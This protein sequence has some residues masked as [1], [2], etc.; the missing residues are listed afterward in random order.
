MKQRSKRVQSC[1]EMSQR[2]AIV[3]CVGVNSQSRNHP[4][5]P[6]SSFLFF[7]VSFF[8]IRIRTRIHSH[9]V[10]YLFIRSLSLRSIF[11][12]QSPKSKHPHKGSISF[13]FISFFHIYFRSHSVQYFFHNGAYS[14]CREIKTSALGNSFF[15]LHF[16]LSHSHSL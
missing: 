3:R 10:R 6:P 8:H 7:G 1:S 5:K 14:H 4:H 12:Q 2:N 11:G 16:S 9:C 15:I 13:F